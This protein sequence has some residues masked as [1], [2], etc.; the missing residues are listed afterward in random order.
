MIYADLKTNLRYYDNRANTRDIVNITKY[1]KVN[2]K[3][4]LFTSPC[5]VIG[6]YVML[7]N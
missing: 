5:E 6:K 4:S 3:T 7:C 2:I 1:I